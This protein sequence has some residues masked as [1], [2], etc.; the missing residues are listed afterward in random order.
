MQKL[1]NKEEEIMHI[2]WKLEKAFERAGPGTLVDPWFGGMRVIIEGPANISFSTRELRVVRFSASFKKISAG[3]NINALSSISNLLGAARSLSAPAKALIKLAEG[4]TL[5]QIRVKALQRT[6]RLVREAYEAAEAFE[7][8]ALADFFKTIPVDAGVFLNMLVASADNGL[9]AVA[10]WGGVSPV[11]PAEEASAFPDQTLSA[12][13]AVS[14]FL[15]ITLNLANAAL[16]GPSPV[17]KAMLAAACAFP[18]ATALQ[19]STIIEH[20][21]R[22][23]AIE[24]RVQINDTAAVIEEVLVTLATSPSVSASSDLLRHVI[25]AKHAAANDISEAIGRLPRV[26]RI[27]L[28]HGT[29]AFLIANHYYGDDPALVEEGYAAIVARNRPRHPAL[30]PTGLLEVLR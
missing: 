16:T 11:A 18:L 15:N 14:G 7:I 30:L 27:N 12:E 1:T 17:D 6:S 24:L 2:L 10:D 5:S 22:D 19:L 3:G 21:A 23:S 26:L 28:E 29:D 20:E 8:V 4:V 13:L 25:L 9:D